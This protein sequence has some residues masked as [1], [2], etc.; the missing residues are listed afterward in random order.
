MCP[1]YGSAS[2]SPRSPV[3][4]SRGK[5]PPAALYFAQDNNDKQLGKC[6]FS[7]SLVVRLCRRGGGGG[8]R[9][10]NESCHCRAS[11]QVDEGSVREGEGRNGT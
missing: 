2:P 9:Y 7:F 5:Q 4:A 8:N 6:I 11:L 3:E 10:G 1:A